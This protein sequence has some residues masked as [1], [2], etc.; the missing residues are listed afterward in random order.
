M[1]QGQGAGSRKE[2]ASQ[3]NNYPTLHRPPFALSLSA[4]NLPTWHAE[5]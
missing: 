5:G 3:T 1:Q 4:Q 2:E